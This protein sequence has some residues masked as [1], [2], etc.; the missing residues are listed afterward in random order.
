MVETKE[1]RYGGHS[2]LAAMV[3]THIHV[4]REA[5]VRRIQQ[6]QYDPNA[7]DY[8]VRELKALDEIETAVKKDLQS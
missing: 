8:F 7:R 2:S 5:L 4:W 6:G 3:S 1:Q